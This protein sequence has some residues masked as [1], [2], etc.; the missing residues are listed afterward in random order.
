[1]L[2]IEI[3]NEEVEEAMPV[4]LLDEDEAKVIVQKWSWELE[5]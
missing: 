4:T 2:V 1:M 3:V 5:R